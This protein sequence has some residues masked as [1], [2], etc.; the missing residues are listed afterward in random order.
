MRQLT[1]NNINPYLCGYDIQ[2]EQTKRYFFCKEMKYLIKR[3][4]FGFKK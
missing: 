2:T 4:W 1:T 3:K